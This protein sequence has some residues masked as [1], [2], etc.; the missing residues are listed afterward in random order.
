MNPCFQSSWIL[1][2]KLERFVVSKIFLSDRPLFSDV[3]RCWA[4]P[5]GKIFFSSLTPWTNC[6]IHPYDRLFKH[7][8]LCP[9]RVNFK[10]KIPPPLL[11]NYIVGFFY[12]LTGVNKTFQWE[13]K[14]CLVKLYNRCPIFRFLQILLNINPLLFKE[15]V[16]SPTPAHF[17]L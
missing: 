13:N 7:D 15:S 5:P 1:Q 3:F 17:T 12:R 2:R 6:C 9:A 10:L 4:P 14:K 16:L 8:D 11:K